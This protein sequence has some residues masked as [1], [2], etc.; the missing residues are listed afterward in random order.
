MKTNAFFI[1]I[2]LLSFSGNTLLA[3]EWYFRVE[4]PGAG[5]VE[6]MALISVQTGSWR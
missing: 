2:T 3:G 1:F 6:K 4:V 5:D